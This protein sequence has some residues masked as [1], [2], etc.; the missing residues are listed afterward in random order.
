MTT[1]VN[2]KYEKYVTY[3]DP[4]NRDEILTRLR[5]LEDHQAVRQ[6]IEETYPTWLLFWISEYS[7]DYSYL[8]K[9]WE[10]ICKLSGQKTQFIVL[11]DW[12]SFD[13]EHK[14]VQAFADRMTHQGFVVRRKEEFG[15]C[16]VCNKAIP[17]KELYEFMVKK[18]LPVP[19]KWSDKCTTCNTTGDKC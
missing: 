13:D 7:D 1:E 19:E 9:N 16:S 14:L 4:D 11:V 6:L 18:R 2:E 3:L 10:T 5:D 17:C 12:I 8:Q 15:T